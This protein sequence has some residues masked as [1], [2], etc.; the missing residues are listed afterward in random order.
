MALDKEKLKAVKGV[1]EHSGHRLGE[2][3]MQ[4]LRG[5]RVGKKEYIDEVIKF[6]KE[7]SQGNINQK[8]Q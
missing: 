4:I 1:H 3:M 7:S 5:S 2:K 6:V 8:F